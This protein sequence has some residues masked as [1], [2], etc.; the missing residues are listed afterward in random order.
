MDCSGNSGLYV[1]QLQNVCRVLPPF[2]LTLD[3]SP[4]QCRRTPSWSS[5][6]TVND[7]DIQAASALLLVI[8]C[9]SVRTRLITT[10][11]CSSSRPGRTLFPRP[12]STP[13][14][15]HALLV[16]TGAPGP[17]HMPSGADAGFPRTTVSA[18][19][20]RD[21]SVASLGVGT[22]SSPDTCWKHLFP[23]QTIEWEWRVLRCFLLWT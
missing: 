2:P 3:L 1:C 23:I 6:W 4:G 22:D 10:C 16:P 13:E 21:G 20:P 18:L 5:T 19:Q 9:R 7:P 14:L 17:P 8:C 11:W 15:L 12:R